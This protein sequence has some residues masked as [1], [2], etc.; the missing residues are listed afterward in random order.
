MA[1]KQEPKKQETSKAE[2]LLEARA[3]ARNK[4]LNFWTQ[5]PQTAMVRAW[6]RR[7]LSLKEV[8]QKMGVSKPVLVSWIKESPML[9]ECFTKH[10][11]SATY[12]AEDILEKK[13]AEGE[14]WAVEL[15]LK[16]FQSGT[17]DPD[18][19]IGCEP[20]KDGRTD[21]MLEIMDIVDGVYSPDDN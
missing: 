10:G 21:V 6:A 3:Q 19:W 14:P 9:R 20:P 18:K 13:V 1:K 15:F 4:R 2:E 5:S 17:Y 16:T 8:A 7:G 12:Y 11:V